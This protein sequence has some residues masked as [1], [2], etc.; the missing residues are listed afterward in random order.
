MEPPRL[1]VRHGH[2]R[3]G[4]ALVALAVAGCEPGATEVDRI[5][6]GVPQQTFSSNSV[7]LEMD[8]GV[9]IAVQV[10]APAPLAPGSAGAIIE[11]TRYWRGAVGFPPAYPVLQAV[12][13]GMAWVTVDERGTGA[14]FG[15]W[16][17]PLTDRSLADFAAVVDWVVSQPWSNG[18]V[19]ATGVSY[20][21]WAAHLLA[22]DAHPALVAV[23][24]ISAP[25]DLYDDAV[26]P[27]GLLSRGFLESWSD[28]VWELDRGRW[29][30]PG[31]VREILPVENDIGGV[32]VDSALAEHQA[33]PDVFVAVSPAE[34]RDETTGL[35]RTLDQM[36]THP[37]AAAIAD[38]GAALYLSAGWLD[39][40]YADGVL[41]HF[42]E[43]DAPQHAVLG[44]WSHGLDENVDPFVPEGSLPVPRFQTHWGEYLNF[45]G[46]R[47]TPGAGPIEEKVLRYYTVGEGVWK[48]TS[49]WPVAGVTPERRYLSAGGALSAAGPSAA[50]AADT[51]AIDFTHRS[52][53]RSRWLGPL[54]LAAR[55]P[56]RAVQDQKLLVYESAPLVSALEITGHPTADLYVAA[57][58][59]D[60]AVIVYL[61]AVL[62]DGRVLYLS[63]GVLR[64]S[65][66]VLES[67]D[68][69][70][71]RATHR[72]ADRA[73]L[74]PGEVTRLSLTLEPISVLVPVGARLRV[75]LAGHDETSFERVPDSGGVTLEVHRDAAHPSSVLLPV[76]P[77]VP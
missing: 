69:V 20:A 10:R 74:V 75:A 47:L 48:A 21:G 68:A 49:T 8:D 50:E 61:E 66:R 41:R 3:I 25:F 44:A 52:A 58:R 9:R 16:P 30:L 36:S 59:S 37:R 12:R 32:L 45:L 77:R 51:Y 38:G 19:A 27:G 29:P 11:L 31:P 54:G 17:G 2:R 46:S 70:L 13:R 43:V 72:A 6:I 33:N 7:Y 5:V 40:G 23:A 14:S 18:R 53:D 24:P 73:P 71:P 60:A 39:A 4:S 35:G 65:H 64:A 28:L 67:A 57:D 1:R 22:A 76:V 63:E 55:Y 56:D 34:F 42:T 62:A 26:R 15:T